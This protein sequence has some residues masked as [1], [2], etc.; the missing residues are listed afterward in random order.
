M[1]LSVRLTGRTNRNQVS[2]TIKK[3]NFQ[4]A[5]I[6]HQVVHLTDETTELKWIE[7]ASTIWACGKSCK[8][9]LLKSYIVW[10]VSIFFFLRYPNL[11]KHLE[12]KLEY[13]GWIISVVLIDKSK[14]G[15]NWNAFFMQC[16]QN[17]V[18][19]VKLQLYLLCLGHSKKIG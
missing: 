13:S 6:Y 17:A 19:F 18:L 9:Q 11:A 15:H 4:C 16:S 3:S 10:Y 12:T 7:L 2:F 5:Q 8:G 14:L 1:L